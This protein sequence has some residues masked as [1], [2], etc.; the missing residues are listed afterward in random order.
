M[1][2]TVALLLPWPC[3]FHFQENLKMAHP[4][5]VVGALT[6]AALEVGRRAWHAGQDVEFA[7]TAAGYS[8]ALA[9]GVYEYFARPDVPQLEAASQ[10]Q[11]PD[12]PASR[13]RHVPRNKT[14][15]QL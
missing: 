3:R 8:A 15:A 13:R 11:G 14:P 12:P 7:V 1:E 10:S 6:A 2:A 5:P 4:R 9:R